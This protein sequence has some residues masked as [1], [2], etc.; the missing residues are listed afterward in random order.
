MRA[1]VFFFLCFSLSFTFSLTA[2]IV[3]V[4]S[5]RELPAFLEKEMLVVFDIDN[6]LIEPQQL[7][8]SDQWFDHRIAEYKKTCS[9]EMAFSK[10]YVEW[11]AIQNLSAM[12]PVESET[13]PLLKKLQQE[14]YTLMALTARSEDFC[15]CTFNQFDS[16]GIDFSPTSP[17]HG[18]FFFLNRLPLL[19]RKGV[20]FTSGTHRGEALSKF[21][22]KIHYFPKSILCI[23]DKQVYLQEMEVVCKK[24][25]IPFIGLRY[26]YLD[27]KVLQFDPKI[28]E[29]QWQAFGHL[30][31]DQVAKEKS[32]QQR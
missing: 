11:V 19:Y 15:H 8:G 10:T 22:K 23:N 17:S 27:Q 1:K 18:D 24:M 21:L 31:S 7:L 3:E 25:A 14:G 12:K 2:K 4:S 13:I 28:A 29:V 6:T 20:L 32:S 26:G 30:L 16:L 9:S 5:I